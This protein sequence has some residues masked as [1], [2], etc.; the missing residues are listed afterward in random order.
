[1]VIPDYLWVAFALGLL[2]VVAWFDTR[3]ITRKA[4]LSAVEAE[5]MARENSK[6]LG[7]ADWV[8]PER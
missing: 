6:P 7:N 4:N 8:W 5:R 1:V 3:R 2:F